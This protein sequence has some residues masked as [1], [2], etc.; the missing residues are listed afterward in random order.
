M[1]DGLEPIGLAGQ[2]SAVRGL[3]VSV[4]GL[5]VALGSSCRIMR[6]SG[7][8]EAR[9]VGFADGRTLVMPMGGMNGIAAGDCVVLGSQRNFVRV[10]GGMLGRVLDAFGRPIDGKGPVATDS[11]VPLWPDPISPMQR[12]RI[13][14]PLPTGVRAIDAMLT[15]GKGQRMGIFSGSGVGKSVLMGMI[16]RHSSADVAVI[17]LIGERGREVRDFIEKDLGS[18]G[19]RRA[20]VIASTGDEPPGVR[21]QAAAMATAVA[22]HFRDQ[23]GDVLLLMDSVTRLASAQRQIGLAAGEPPATKGYTP[24]VFNLL[25]QLLE[26]GGQAGGGSITGF[27]TVLVEGDDLAEPVSDA[28]RS[29]TDGHIVLSRDLANRGHYP[30]I[31]VL[32][33]VSR[34]MGDVTD[35]EHRLAVREAHRLMVLFGEIEALVAIGAYRQGVSSEYDLAIKAM[36]LIRG[37][38]SQPVNE[39]SEFGKTLAALKELQRQIQGLRQRVSGSGSGSGTGAGAVVDSTSGKH[40]AALRD[41]GKVAFGGAGGGMIRPQGAWVRDKR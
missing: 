12:R 15:V 34:V 38:L 24:S 11:Q 40:S 14:T 37:F 13:Q 33:S 10:G 23:G 39:P 3:T 6:A 7:E 9:V 25:P 31:D 35:G 19:L 22:E 26:R 16:C 20:V 21:V 17:A 5:P 4:I 18:Q 32:Q 30:A 29:I 36:P 27:Y 28:V 8:L 41:R 2:V 1:L